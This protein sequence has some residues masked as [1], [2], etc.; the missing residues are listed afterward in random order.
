MTALI[1]DD[2]KHCREV[3]DHLIHKYCP[4]ISIIES[5]DSGEAA[6]G[7]LHDHHPDIL[8]LD[9]EMP[10][11]NGFDVLEKCEH[12]S[13]EVIFTTAYN[14][15]AIKAIRHSALDYLLKPI[16]KGELILAVHRAIQ[17]KR[18]APSGRIEELLTKLSSK[19]NVKRFA[20]AAL[21]GLI[22]VNAD[23]IL[24]CESD[25]AYCNLVFLNGKSLLLSKTLKDVEDV[26]HQDEF[27][28][29]HNSYL[30][31]LQ[32]VS[33]YIKGEG[34]EVIM[35]NGKHLPVSRTRKHD[36]LKL[37]ERI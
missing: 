27:C 34:G 29:I 20:A 14:E 19:K 12:P 26:L 15:Y 1:V 3:L 36:F 18:N 2:E 16:D 21:E 33:K 30:I 11:M 32:Y 17:Y 7:I 37:L 10:G 13:F 4:E 28:R 24:Y 8:F 31:N 5:C 22:M 35:N 6:L 23:D 9:I 25:S